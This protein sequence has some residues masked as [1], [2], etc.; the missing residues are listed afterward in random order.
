MFSPY[1]FSVTLT[2]IKII[3]LFQSCLQHAN[4]SHQRKIHSIDYQFSVVMV[5]YQLMKQLAHFT[6]VYKFIGAMFDFDN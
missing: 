3:H 4:K 6:K 2:A 5:F 1:L